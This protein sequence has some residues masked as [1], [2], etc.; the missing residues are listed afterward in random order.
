MSRSTQPLAARLKKLETALERSAS[1]RIGELISFDPMIA[2][3][4]VSRPMLRDWCR[5]IPGFQTSGCFVTGDRGIKWEFEPRAT[6]LFL[7]RH[8]ERERD[9]AVA[10]ARALKEIA[11]GGALEAMPDGFSLR[12]ARELVQMSNAVQEMRIRQGELIEANR[13]A[14]AIR[15]MFGAMQAAG[16]QAAQKMDPLG[17]WP[18]DIRSVVE[19]E[20]RTVL[21]EQQRAA[22]TCLAGI[23]RPGLDDDGGA[24][25]PG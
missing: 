17:Q 7:L 11:G 19:D 14:D 12:E 25:K 1:Y 22:Q 10:K 23:G 16:L 13:T 8:F 6:I 21:L 3:L 24:A 9:E 15:E 20:M 4:G 2:L 5:D 18:P